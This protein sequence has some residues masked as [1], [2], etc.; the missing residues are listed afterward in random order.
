MHMQIEFAAAGGTAGAMARAEER[1]LFM[2][3]LR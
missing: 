3:G 2:V 1:R